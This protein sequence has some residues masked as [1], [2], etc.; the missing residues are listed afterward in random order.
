MHDVQSLFGVSSHLS[1]SVYSMQSSIHALTV[2]QSPMLVTQ[3]SSQTSS[4]APS[5]CNSAISAGHP[6][7][8]LNVM[9]APGTVHVSLSLEESPLA[10]VHSDDHPGAFLS[11]HGLAHVF[12]KMVNSI[13]DEGKKE[14]AFDFEPTTSMSCPT[15]PLR[16]TSSSDT[17]EKEVTY[18]M[19][20]N[21][22][23]ATIE[24]EYGNEDDEIVF[25]YG[26]AVSLI[27]SRAP[28]KSRCSVPTLMSSRGFPGDTLVPSHLCCH[29]GLARNL[30]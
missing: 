30:L 18:P 12:A 17:I 11:A 23:T 28:F 13:L 27:P 6:T 1:A 9:A 24:C 2:R 20:Q 5:S 8:A 19:L 21:V 26:D 14:V 22:F 7:V 25:E 4:D 3:Q 15:A 10:T 29:L 16:Q